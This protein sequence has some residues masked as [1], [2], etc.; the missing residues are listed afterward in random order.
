MRR[1]CAAIKPMRGMRQARGLTTAGA[2]IRGLRERLEVEHVPK[3]REVIEAQLA[4]FDRS[5]P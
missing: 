1:L 2:R 5:R 4:A 3:V